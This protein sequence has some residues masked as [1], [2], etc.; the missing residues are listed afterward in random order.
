MK[1]VFIS[2]YFNH[3]QKTFCEELFRKLGHDFWFVSTSAISEKRKKLGYKEEVPRYVL[4]VWND[5]QNQAVALELINNADVVI[6]G[7]ASDRMLTERNRTGKLVIR[8]SERPFKKE[9]SFLRKLYHAVRFR[10]RDRGN[11]NVYLLCA[12]AYAAADFAS[13]GMYSGR[14]YKWGYFPV[15]KE[16]NME[17]LLV[18]KRQNTLLWCG[19]FIDWKHPDDAIRLAGRLKESGCD[20]QLNMIGTGDMEEELMCL[21][22]TYDVTDVV[23]FLGSMPP[24]Q[25]R[26]HMEEA[27]IYLFTSDRQEGWGAVLNEAMSSGCAVVASHAAGSTP[28]LLRHNQNGL[29]YRSGD[30]DELYAMVKQLLENP[31]KQRTLGQAAYQTVTNEWN[32]GIAAQR[33]LNIAQHILSGNNPRTI[34]DTGPCSEAPLIINDWT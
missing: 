10:K 6:A 34:Y 23:H 7:A 8:Y 33:F 5:P 4:P 21:A 20:F 19:R 3:H 1:V 24:D 16:Y 28:F 26:T 14:M 32:A 18:E 30:S 25:V 11:R 15:V 12:S 13:V 31:E 29:M 2:N 17:R 22:K 9:P 27:G